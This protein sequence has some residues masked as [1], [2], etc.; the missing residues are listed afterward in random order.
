MYL[1]SKLIIDSKSVYDESKPKKISILKFLGIT[2]YKST[3]FQTDSNIQ[4]V[5]INSK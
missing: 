3:K 2:I 1:F 5:I 4:E